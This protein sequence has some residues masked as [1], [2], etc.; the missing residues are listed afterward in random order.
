MWT[1]V[2]SAVGVPTPTSAYSTA[3]AGPQVSAHELGAAEA[4]A[5][6]QGVVIGRLLLVI[7]HHQRL[8]QA[9]GPAQL[10]AEL[11]RVEVFRV[12]VDGHQADP[13]GPVEQ[14]PHRRP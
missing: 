9:E 3:P 1:M 5:G 10:T 11:E 4:D 14:P 6:V 12:E 7:G 13:P 2:A 8:G